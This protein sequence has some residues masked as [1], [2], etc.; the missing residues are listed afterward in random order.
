MSSKPTNAPRFVRAL[1]Y[2][3]QTYLVELQNCRYDN[4]R[5]EL[6]SDL[7]VSRLVDRQLKSSLFGRANPTR[8]LE[9][10]FANDCTT[11]KI[12]PVDEFHDYTKQRIANPHNCPLLLDA[13]LLWE[14]RRF[15]LSEVYK[16]E[17]K[18]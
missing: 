7:T 5:G 9:T 13:P 14:I 18:K 16:P 15:A 6:T 12:D 11:F 3:G 2:E 17:S 4:E 8:V 10:V 1:E